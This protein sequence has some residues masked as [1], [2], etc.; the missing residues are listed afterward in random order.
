MSLPT[1][2]QASGKRKE[3]I[4]MPFHKNNPFNTAI[5]LNVNA[6]RS[7]THKDDKGLQRFYQVLQLPLK[8][9][10]Y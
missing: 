3:T 8:L 6:T 2:E 5:C 4:L 10:C 9:I 7:Y 1:K